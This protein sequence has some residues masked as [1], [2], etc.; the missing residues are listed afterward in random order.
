MAVATYVGIVREGRI[1]LAEPVTLPEGSQVYV[2]VPTVIDERL[3]HRKANRWLI[4]N[5]GNMVMADRAA[6]V[7]SA[8]RSVWRFGAFI[9]ALSHEPLGP[10][11][12][13]EVDAVNGE[14]LA[15]VHLAEEM[16]RR[17]ERFEHSPPPSEG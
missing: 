17:G 16:V 1:H 9:T 6:L 7:Q 11:G 14:V 4:E 3:A 12:H 10:I 8:G 13:I 2:V 5:V 15:D